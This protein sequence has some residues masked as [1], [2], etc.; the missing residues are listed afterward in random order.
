MESGSDGAIRTITWSKTHE[1]TQIVERIRST[2]Q[3]AEDDAAAFAVGLKLFSEVMLKNKG[4]PLFS[5]FQ[6]HF[7]SFMKKLKA[8]A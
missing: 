3:F 7:M 4:N 5:E 8:S 2:Q 6:P 1:I